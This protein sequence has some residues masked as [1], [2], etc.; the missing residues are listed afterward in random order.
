[1]VSVGAHSH[2]SH[3]W[4]RISRAFG[5]AAPHLLGRIDLLLPFFLRSLEAE[6]NDGESPDHLS[7]LILGVSPK[8][9]IQFLFFFSARMAEAKKGGS[10]W[11][12]L[13]LGLLGTSLT[14]VSRTGFFSRDCK[15]LVT[16]QFKERDRVDACRCYKRILNV[17]DH[18][19]R[20]SRQTFYPSN[21]YINTHVNIHLE[22]RTFELT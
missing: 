20:V 15:E 18:G 13:T 22:S 5:P 16:R 4:V 14:P 1:M 3:T 17:F 19:E 7:A 2:D 9:N 12:T 21:R 8:Q 11:P 10:N 6:V